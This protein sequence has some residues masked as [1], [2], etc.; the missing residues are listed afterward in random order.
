MRRKLLFSLIGIMV[1]AYGALLATVFTSSKPALGLDLQGGISVT[2]RAVSGADCSQASMQLA[3]EKI[4]ER[5]DSLGVAEPEILCQGDTIVVNL[6]GVRNQQQAVDLVQVTGQVYLRPVVSQCQILNIPDP[7]AT[8]TSVDGASTTT[9]AATGSTTAT[10]APSSST[11]S[12]SS[13]APSTTAAGGPSRPLSAG[14]TTT[15]TVPASTTTAAGSTTSTVPA[16]STTSTTSP[17]LDANGIPVQKS[18]PNTTQVLPVFGSNPPQYCPVGPAQGTGEVFQ[19]DASATIITGQGWGVVVNLRSGA[20]GE[21]V[22]NNLAKQCFNKETACPTQQ[23]SI[24][25]DGSLQS[26]ATVQTANFNGSVQ[27]SGSFTEGEAKN[28][29]R[30]L[31]SGS[32]PVELE[33]QSVQNVSASLGKDSLRAAVISGAIGVLLVLLFMVAYYRLLG[34]IVAVGITVSA[35][36]LWGIIVWLSRTNGLALSLSGIAGIIV[37]VGVTVDSYVVFFER[38][39]DEVRSGKTLRNSATRGFQGAWRTIVIADLVSLIGALVLWYLTVGAVRGFAFFLGLSTLCD[40]IVAYLFTR[41]TVLLLARTKWMERRKV[42]GIEV[43][44]HGATA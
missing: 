28:L 43:T 10:T 4:R 39:K 31:N 3:V 40:L 11:V 25:L 42:M 29:A 38:L 18:D 22:W 41:P 6:P 20:N 2:Q 8:T 19:D 30:V 9:G 15:S 37:S 1:V 27:I 16:G 13:T 36:L 34:L 33:L 35:S 24:D 17:A 7:N 21:D 44:P 12:A 5:V 32:L 14:N 23:I 26:V